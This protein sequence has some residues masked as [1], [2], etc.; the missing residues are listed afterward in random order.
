VAK[1]RRA[2]RKGRDRGV[3]H[4]V[5]GLVVSESYSSIRTYTKLRLQAGQEIVTQHFPWFFSF[6][7]GSSVNPE[8]QVAVNL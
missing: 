6:L 2:D 5:A 7:K 3:K 8:R 1:S 4:I